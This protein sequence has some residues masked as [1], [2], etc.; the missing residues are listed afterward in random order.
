MGLPPRNMAGKKLRMQGLMLGRSSWVDSL[1]VW[2][3]ALWMPLVVDATREKSFAY[4]QVVS[5]WALLPLLT[6]HIL[7][8]RRPWISLTRSNGGRL[9]QGDAVRATVT[10]QC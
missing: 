1:F 10:H 8:C 6:D 4:S 3:P 2:F 5:S 7:C 9:T